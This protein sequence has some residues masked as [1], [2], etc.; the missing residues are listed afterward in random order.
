MAQVTIYLDDETRALMEQAARAD[1][2]SQSR[3]VAQL[4]RQRTCRTWP[5]GWESLIGSFP[6]F[7]LRQDPPQTDDVPR[8]GF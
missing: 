3:W 4:I 5:E 8:I 7:P 2:V 6:D 1:G